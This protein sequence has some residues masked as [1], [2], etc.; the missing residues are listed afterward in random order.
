MSYLIISASLLA[1]LTIV[2]GYSVWSKNSEITSAIKKSEEVKIAK[3]R[4]SSYG[5]HT[6]NGISTKSD[7]SKNTNIST[8]VLNSISAKQKQNLDNFQKAIKVALND[9]IKNPTCTDL[10][11]TGFITKSDCEAI[12]K[13]NNNFVGIENGKINILNEKISA[14]INNTEHC[15]NGG[16]A[17]VNPDGTVAY[18]LCDSSSLKVDRNQ[19]KKKL[20]S[21]KQLKEIVN[22]SND[23][24]FLKDLGNTLVEKYENNKSYM[25]LVKLKEV[26][27]R[28]EYLKLK[29]QLES[30][31]DKNKIKKLQ[32]DYLK[33]KKLLDESNDFNYIK[34]RLNI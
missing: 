3:R 32:D 21:N 31:S 12:I 28:I 8:L 15:I 5:A 9:N 22:H 2:S 16:K 27:D 24:Q 19:L 30:E 11:D 17:I 18:K 23:I 13:G 1:A 4:V 25:D 7:V 6:L 20:K 14:I 26:V 10:E 29:E 33:N 34:K